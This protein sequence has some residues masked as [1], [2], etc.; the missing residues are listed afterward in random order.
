[1]DAFGFG[2][3]VVDV[4]MVGGLC[5]YFVEFFITDECEYDVL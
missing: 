1:M 4:L 2:A 3:D 5:F